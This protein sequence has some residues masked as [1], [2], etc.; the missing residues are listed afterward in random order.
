MG[1]V[2]YA[3]RGNKPVLLVGKA[4]GTF[5]ERD[6]RRKVERSLG[7][8]VVTGGNSATIR[9]Y[10]NNKMVKVY[11]AVNFQ[12][13]VIM[14]KNGFCTPHIRNNVE[15]NVGIIK[16]GYLRVGSNGLPVK[17]VNGRP[18]VINEEFVPSNMIVPKFDGLDTFDAVQKD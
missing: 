16:I 6:I 7:L 12:E 15:K 17:D 4:N 2:D 10:Y 11:G 14:D 5:A 13:G 3:A 18:Y 1:L 9:Y 8:K